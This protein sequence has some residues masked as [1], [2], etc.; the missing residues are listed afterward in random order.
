MRLCN[1]T[2]AATTTAR[3]TQ[4]TAD[5][6]VAV[7]RHYQSCKH[8]KNRVHTNTVLSFAQQ[9]QR[10]TATIAEGSSQVVDG[11]ECIYVSI[12]Q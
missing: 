6:A 12:D 4:C 5:A 1:S 3:V 8:N 2:T 11:R 9:G 7:A 10:D